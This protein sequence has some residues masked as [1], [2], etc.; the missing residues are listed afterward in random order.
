MKPNL[1]VVTMSAIILLGLVSF[2]MLSYNV[3]RAIFYG[4]VKFNF[5]FNAG[6]F[7]VCIGAFIVITAEQR[8]Q[9][10]Q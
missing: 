8:K 1:W 5:I 4:S 7:V 6:L 3:A 9:N 2:S 10:V